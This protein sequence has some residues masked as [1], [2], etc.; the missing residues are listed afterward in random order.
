MNV[1]VQRN[2]FGFNLGLHLAFVLKTRKKLSFALVGSRRLSL[3]LA[4][5]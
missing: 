3:V 2:E 5:S 1:W 4:N